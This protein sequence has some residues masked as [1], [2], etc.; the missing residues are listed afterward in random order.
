M[1]PE[2]SGG[3][4]TKY[5][6]LVISFLCGSFLSGWFLGAL[7]VWS[8]SLSLLGAIVAALTY[9]A[10]SKGHRAGGG[11]FG[12]NRK[13]LHLAGGSA[14]IL[15]L[16]LCPTDLPLLTLILFI[17]YSLYEVL[18]WQV[19]KRKIWTS[20]LLSFYGSPEE[21]SGR[22]FWEAILGL[23]AVCGVIYFFDLKITLVALINLTFGDGIAGLT[24][25][26]LGEDARSFGALKGWWGS[27]AGTVASSLLA[28]V[29]TG[30]V[31]SLIP[32][33]VGML[34]E[35]LPLPVDDNLTVPLSTALSAWLLL[36]F[37]PGLLG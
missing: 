31:S 23:G 35:R 29:L 2:A 7:S 36:E 30:K 11:S 34:V 27:L 25:E 24:R 19:A 9:G 32:V 6:A 1:R 12:L 22:P 26:R 17:T 15:G 13:F 21:Q 33:A 10:L 14:L 16:I 37:Y 8:A 3:L 5:D 28:L 4:L 18:R 20:E